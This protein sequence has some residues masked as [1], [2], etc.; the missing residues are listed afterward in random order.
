MKNTLWRQGALLFC[1]ILTL[2]ASACGDSRWRTA[3][4]AFCTDGY[5]GEVAW[6]VNG[7]SYTGH[8]TLSAGEA[9][10]GAREASLTYASPAALAGVT[11]RAASGGLTLSLDGVT[12]EAERQVAD[13]LLGILRFFSPARAALAREDGRGGLTFSDEEGDYAVRFDGNGRVCELCFSSPTL[14]LRL[15]PGGAA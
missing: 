4:T 12:H 11:V 15:L 5:E 1:I 10:P 13:S 3:Y 6:S 14:S 8:L 2:A 7:R 9:E